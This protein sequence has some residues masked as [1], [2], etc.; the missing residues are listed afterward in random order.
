MITVLFSFL[1]ISSFAILYTTLENSRSV[2][3]LSI[4]ALENTALAISTSAENILQTSESNSDR[5]IS[6]IFSDR[7]V[8]Y[9]LIV[10][11]DGTIL[12]HTNPDLVGSHL[13]GEDLKQWLKSE[14]SSGR[15]ITLRTGLPA[16]EFNYIL[17]RLDGTPEMLKL[18]LH[19]TQADRVVS[20]AQ[21]MWLTV[22]IVLIL[23]WTGGIFSWRIFVRHMSLQEELG[24]R[25]QLALV[26]QMTAVLAHEIRNAL[27]SIKGYTQWVDEKVEELDPR[28][29]GLAMVL[30]G[31]DRIESL[32]NDLLLFSR[33]ETYNIKKLDL[34]RLVEEAA[35]SFIPSWEGKIDL[36]IKPGIH[37]MADR[38]KLYRALINGIQNAV[39]TMVPDGNLRISTS[40]EGRWVKIQVEDT[41]QGI[42]ESE[43]SHLFVPFYTTKSN[44]TGLGLAYSKKVVEGMG[45]KINLSNREDRGGAV[46]TIDLLKA[47]GELR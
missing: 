4:Q 12:Y 37:V 30:K 35:S 27:G 42:Q 46:L 23:L 22:I 44:G 32:V 2:K 40:L 39:Q 3:S 10:R 14:T 13:S 24:R 20:Q 47:G 45:G 31:T 43:L 7:V 33:E 8:A 34:S 21:R 15:R 38:E 1:L 18:V 19:T 28:K 41:G 25:K 29:A 17:H 9:A 16:Y 6:E 5:E 36:D 26:G 11:K